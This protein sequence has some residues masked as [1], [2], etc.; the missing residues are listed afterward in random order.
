MNE[1]Q[2]PQGFVAAGANVGIKNSKPDCGI[3]LS[4]SPAVFAACVTQNKS[5]APNAARIERL[6]QGEGSVRAVLTLSGNANA[7]TGEAGVKDDLQVAEAVAKQLGINPEQVLTAYTGVVGHRLPVQR[8]V[9]GLPGVLSQLTRDPQDFAKSVLTTDKVTKLQSREIFI[10]GHRVHVQAVAKGSG[11]IAPAL[12]T[13]LV[14]LTTDAAISKALLQKALSGAVDDSLNQLTIDQE[15]ST[16]DA[17]MALANGLAENPTIETEGPDFETF[18]GAVQDIF[19]EVARSIADDGEGATRRIEVEITGA[20]TRDNARAFARSV[21]G[22]ML[23]KS[24]VFG[25]DPNMAGRVMATVGACACRCD[26]PLD[27][28][29]V[30]L[31]IEGWCF[32]KDGAMLPIEDPTQVR[33]RLSSPVIRFVLDLGLGQGKARAFGCDLSY[34]YV[35]INAD[36]AAITKTSADGR[37]AVN[38]RLADLGPTIKHKILVQALAYMERFKGIRAVIKLGGAAMVD[39]K[40]EAQFAQ[41]VLLLRAVGLKPIVVHGGAPEITETMKRL[42]REAEFVDGLRVTDS[43]SMGVVEMVLTGS[44]NQRLVAA[45]N[46]EGSTAVG[47]SGKDG[48]LIRAR[49]MTMDR[50]LGQVGEVERIDTRLIDLLER[51]NYIPVISPVGLGDD[52]SAYNLD[53]DVVA[54]ELASALD[55]RKL[56]FLCDAPG[57]IEGDKVTSELDGDQLKRRLDAGEVEASMQPMMQAAL[58]ALRGGLASVHLVD[59]RVRHNLIAELFTDSGVGTVIRHA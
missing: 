7:L 36:Y 56:I 6:V 58:R 51:D 48:G 16:N 34:D 15:M 24:A 53:S 43:A 55:A 18:Y 25:A 49:K 32:F 8:V 40:L 13:T 10:A 42:G 27:L 2:L 17:V 5:R 22:S 21:A 59:G 19:T 12:A 31:H 3:L 29:K 11:M 23:I 28:T 4:E 20:S 52:G 37:V 33:H 38:E 46:Q 41:D 9:A 1:H 35:K 44:V 50:N 30:I 14:F 39:P 47:I 54:A 26:E 57:L 45:L